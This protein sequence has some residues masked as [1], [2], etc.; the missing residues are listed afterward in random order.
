M[1]IICPGYTSG[2]EVYS[3]GLGVHSMGGAEG[4]KNGFPEQMWV[5]PSA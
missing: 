5:G 2:G 3:L 1:D 4:R